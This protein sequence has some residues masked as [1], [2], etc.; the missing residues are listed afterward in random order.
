MGIHQGMRFKNLSLENTKR[1]LKL[2]FVG[3]QLSY[4]KEALNF[5][6][7]TQLRVYQLKQI[8]IS[9]NKQIN[10]NKF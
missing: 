5:L 3:R 4:T 9:K 2:L 10:R 1:L 7:E 6:V 8:H